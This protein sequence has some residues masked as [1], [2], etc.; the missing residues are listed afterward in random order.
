[1]NTNFSGSTTTTTTTTTATTTTT[2]TTTTITR[3]A[4]RRLGAL[5]RCAAVL[6]AYSWSLMREKEGTILEYVIVYYDIL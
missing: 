3:L 6:A 4:A 2:T 5:R 1:M